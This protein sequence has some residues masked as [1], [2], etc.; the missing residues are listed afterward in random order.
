[1]EK[2]DCQ[3]DLPDL[4]FQ[5]WESHPHTA[6]SNPILVPKKK[7]KNSMQTKQVLNLI[8]KSTNK[9][10]SFKFLNYSTN[11]KDRVKEPICNTKLPKL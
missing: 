7:L 10:Q 3:S 8:F 5:Q 2:D 9:V 1:M 6:I 11:Y 4:Y